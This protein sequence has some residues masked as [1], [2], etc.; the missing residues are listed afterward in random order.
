M[1]TKKITILLLLFL[2]LVFIGLDLSPILKKESLKDISFSDF[3][4]SIGPVLTFIAVCLS[5]RTEI[6]KERNTKQSNS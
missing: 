5:Y 4:N 6:K 3:R 2:I 1:T